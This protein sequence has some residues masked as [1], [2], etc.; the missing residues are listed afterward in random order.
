MWLW[1]LWVVLGFG[2]PWSVGCS[3]LLGRALLADVRLLGWVGMLMGGWNPELSHRHCP[4]SGEPRAL[5][6]VL[7][8][9]EE[10][11]GLFALCSELFRCSQNHP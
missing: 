3:C 7:Q 4:S 10:R 5:T 6:R 11:R 2:E 9:G 1:P 8:R